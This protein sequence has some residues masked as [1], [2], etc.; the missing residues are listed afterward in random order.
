MGGH[1]HRDARP[2]LERDAGHEIDPHAPLVVALARRHREREHA[3]ATVHLVGHQLRSEL[4]RVH[5]TVEQKA[6]RVA[7]R[8]ALAA[9]AADEARACVEHDRA[10]SRV[11]DGLARQ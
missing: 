5:R 4:P 2:R 9:G 11:V 6:H 7:G 1:G 8:D 10:R 3:P